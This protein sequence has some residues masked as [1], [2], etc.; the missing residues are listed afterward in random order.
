MDVGLAEVMS[1]GRRALARGDWTVARAR[2]EQAAQSMTS[3]EVLDCLAQARF[4]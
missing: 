3:G 4:S 2:F 1:E